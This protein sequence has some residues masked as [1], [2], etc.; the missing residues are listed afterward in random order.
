MP[1]VYKT[2]YDEL[3]DELG[4]YPINTAD[5]TSAQTNF[6]IAQKYWAKVKSLA[7]E[8]GF[9][10]DEDE[11]DF[12]KNVKP[13]FLHH[14]QLSVLLS[15]ALLSLP[16]KPDLVRRYWLYESRRFPRFLEHHAEFVE[17]YEAGL[18]L[19]DPA[20]FLRRHRV[21]A[22]LAIVRFD[23]DPDWNTQHDATV[24]SYLALQ[25]YHE[26]VKEQLG[27]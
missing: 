27:E 6:A 23:T 10:G 25:R 14:L 13:L 20:F 19:I 7:V 9:D 15:A 1:P 8:H 21:N 24:C 22:N 4:P 3:L 12:F 18:R 5:I 2:L 11:I 17:Y 16:H 26:L